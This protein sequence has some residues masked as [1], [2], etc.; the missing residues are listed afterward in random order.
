MI[1][2]IRIGFSTRSSYRARIKPSTEQE[3]EW[4]N[5]VDIPPNPGT[6]ATYQ[7]MVRPTPLAKA[8]HLKTLPSSSGQDAG[9]S[10]RKQGF[11]SPRERH[12]PVGSDGCRQLAAQGQHTQDQQ[13]TKQCKNQK[14]AIEVAMSME[15]HA[16]KR[17]PA[18][19]HTAM[20]E[21]YW[22]PNLVGKTIPLSTSSNA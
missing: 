5:L 8:D 21:S 19:T 3:I 14:A 16:Q 12:I 9:L 7:K 22:G 2:K 13:G 1:M 20:A 4:K 6:I 18:D 10:R 17:R 11:D 15:E